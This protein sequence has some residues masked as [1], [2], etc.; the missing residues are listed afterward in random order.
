MRT[1][2][3]HDLRYQKTIAAPIAF[4][5]IGLHSGERVTMLLRPA[6]VGQGITLVRRDLPFSEQRFDVHWEAVRNSTLCTAIGNAFGH[7]VSTVEHLLSA[8][9]AVGIDNVIIELD[10]PEIPI[11]DGSTLPFVDALEKVGVLSLGASRDVIVIRRPIR[12]QQGAAWAELLPDPGR[13]ITVSIDFDAH[14]IGTQSMSIDITPSVYRREIAPA[15]TF[16]F[17][18]QLD[19]LRR[20]GL[21]LGGS[22]KNAILVRKG[23]VANLEGL[24]FP[25]EFV[26]HKVLDVIGDLSLAGAPIVGHYRGHRP[27]HQ[28]NT[29]LVA[30]LMEDTDAWVSV[31]VADL[32]QVF[33][34]V[35]EGSEA[36]PDAHHTASEEVVREL[37]RRLL[38]NPLADRIRQLFANGSE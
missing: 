16:G 17:A 4:V 38:R 37:P 36:L 23:R 27:G 14:V 1:C 32:D 13:R 3:L 6:A 22:I 21:A 33:D 30:L 31:S 25:D 15:R 18:E 19:H 11:M 9:A 10:G 29:D 20:R 7:E 26:R 8:L 28:L 34:E 24:R 5:G 12:I 2:H 35:F